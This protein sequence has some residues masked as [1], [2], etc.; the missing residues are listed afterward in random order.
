MYYI[1]YHAKK[2]LALLTWLRNYRCFMRAQSPGGQAQTCA[3]EQALPLCSDVVCE[4]T[5]IIWEEWGTHKNIDV[6]NILS[7][8]VIS[9]V[10]Q[11]LE[12]VHFINI[13]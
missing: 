11:P 2:Y 8:D 7:V 13:C 4:D 9:A 12:R 6:C 10:K 5:L 3:H 1:L